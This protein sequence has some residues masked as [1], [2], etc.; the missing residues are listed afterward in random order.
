MLVVSICLCC[1]ACVRDGLDVFCLDALLLG[2]VF[3]CVIICSCLRLFVCSIDCLLVVVLLCLILRCFSSDLFCWL[4]LLW[5]GFVRYELRW[6][7]LV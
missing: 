6:L 1:F 3:V 5:F 2:F 4:A 7:D